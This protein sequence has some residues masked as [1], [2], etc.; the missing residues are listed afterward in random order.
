M[1]NHREQ[2]DSYFFNYANGKPIYTMFIVMFCS[3]ALIA[4]SCS[5]NSTG[6]ND[7]S[8]SNGGGNDD[9][10]TPTEPTFTN[11][12]EIFES[13][14]GGV[15][16]HISNQRSGVRID[17]YDNATNSEGDQYGKLVIQE[18]DA[19]GSPIV[20]KIESSNPEHGDRMPPGGPFLSS[21]EIDLIK[22]WINDGAKNN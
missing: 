8:S 18:G 3:L 14:C 20:D 1:G 19:A 12:Q 6:T 7:G 2:N 10:S 17:T 22:E 16:C 9:G 21:D 4:V 13:S 5:D 11:V 15:N